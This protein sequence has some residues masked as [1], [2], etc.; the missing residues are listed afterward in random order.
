MGRMDGKVV[1]VTGAAR[2]QG[3]SHA[4]RLAEEG[5]DIIAVD[6]CDGVPTIRYAMPDAADLAHTAALVE[7]LDRR[8]VTAVADVRDL[9]ALI[10]AVQRG[11]EELGRLD[12]VVANA[13]VV[14]A[15]LSWE[16]SEDQFD[17]LVAINLGG[18]WRTVKAAVPHLIRQG[19]GGSIIL[20]S[21]IAGMMGFGGYSHYSAS[22]HGVI[23]LMRSLVNELSPYA[24]RVNTVNP[25]TVD[26]PMIQNDDFYSA[27]GATEQEQFADAFQTMHTLPVPWI[28]AADVSNAVL[29]LASDEARY[30]TGLVMNV[31]AG[32]VTKVG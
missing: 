11:V 19:D 5:A 9:A 1:L 21:S 12:V 4:L 30:V 3:R 25:T 27:F 7:K 10:D 13:G 29:Y 15:G 22:K 32:F 31:D 28:E 8:I 14:G 24:V 18:V 2:G 23:G 26:T 20:T 6:R 16:L 17:E